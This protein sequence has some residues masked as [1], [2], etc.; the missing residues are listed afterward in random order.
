ME[1]QGTHSYKRWST[2]HMVKDLGKVNTYRVDWQNDTSN[3]NGIII[4]QNMKR[5]KGMHMYIVSNKRG[6]EEHLS[7]HWNE[8]RKTLIDLQINSDPPTME[9]MMEEGVPNEEDWGTKHFHSPKGLKKIIEESNRKDVK[10]KG[11]TSVNGS[12]KDKGGHEAIY[13]SD[14]NTIHKRYNPEEF[15]Y[16]DGSCIKKRDGNKVGSGIYIPSKGGKAIFLDPGGE[17]PTKTIN[18]AELMPILYILKNEAEDMGDIHILSD[19]LTSIYQIHGYMMDPNK[20]VIHKH[21]EILEDIAKALIKRSEEGKY[22]LISKVPAHKG[23]QGNEEADSAAKK[24]A[25]REEGV[26]I[27]SME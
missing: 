6:K 13:R 23:V 5:E 17:G 10:D 1:D 26:G 19:S 9:D 22:T 7:R 8:V 21:K 27:V 20:Y 3:E 4:S 15:I 11:T 24:A 14:A 12:V 18:R 16:T 2:H 25:L